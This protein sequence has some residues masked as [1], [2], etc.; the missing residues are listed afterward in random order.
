MAIN[1]QLEYEVE[2]ILRK[3]IR[4]GK[5]EYLVEWRGYRPEDSTWEPLSNLDNASDLIKEFNSRNISQ[6]ILMITRSDDTS[7]DVKVSG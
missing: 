7:I 5:T 3:R 4:R 6:S 2:R 1:D